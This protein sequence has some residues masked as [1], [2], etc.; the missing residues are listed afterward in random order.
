MKVVD[1]FAKF[2]TLFKP[3]SFDKPYLFLMNQ[4]GHICLSFIFCYLINLPYLVFMFWVVWETIHLIKSKDIID[5]FE[6]LT[7]EILGVVLF[8]TLHTAHFKIW[9][10]TILMGVLSYT[11]VKFKI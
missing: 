5:F 11:Y 2:I 9:L 1:I 8:L 7:F 4:F 10:I 6:D 3:Q